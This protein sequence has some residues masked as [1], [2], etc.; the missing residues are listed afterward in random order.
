LTARAYE[1]EIFAPVAPVITFTD[2]EETARLARG[3]QYGL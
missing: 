3:T 2:I 1:E